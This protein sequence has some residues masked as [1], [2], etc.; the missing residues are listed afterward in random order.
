MKTTLPLLVGLA[1]AGAEA[2]WAQDPPNPGP[3]QPPPEQ[4]GPSPNYTTPVP[5]I[6]N[7][8]F[9]TNQFVNQ[10]WFTNMTLVQQRYLLRWISVNPWA[11]PNFL[12][13]E[14]ALTNVEWNTNRFGVPPWAHQMTN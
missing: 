5:R 11:L 4:P 6:Q 3:G 14:S 13:N 8:L 10:S 9:L 2:G 1:L 7:P 12:T